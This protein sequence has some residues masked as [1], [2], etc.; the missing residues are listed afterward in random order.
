MEQ[1][2]DESGARAARGPKWRAP[3]VAG[4]LAVTGWVC[5]VP[6]EPP[7]PDGSETPPAGPPART[8]P[9]LGTPERYAE[10]LVALVNA[11][12]LRAG[13]D[14]L[15]SSGP[16]RAAAQGHADDMAARGYYEHRD[17]DG[18]DGGD[19]ITAAGYDW[20]AWGENIHRGPKTPATAMRDW[21]DS[22]AHR[23]NIV[24]CSFKDLGV[25]VNLRAN[26]PWWVQVFGAKG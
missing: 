22:A 16:L 24:N 3:A 25:G 2:D 6:P 10:Q 1:R 11:E 7:R 5:L 20:R 19:R 15:R 8:E 23:R 12:R 21:M 4:V 26:G 17:P 9:G 14:P 13:C 18:S